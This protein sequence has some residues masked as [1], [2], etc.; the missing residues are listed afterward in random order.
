MASE[1]SMQIM[2]PPELSLSDIHE[3]IV[4]RSYSVSEPARSRELSGV[5][6]EPAPGAECKLTVP[7]PNNFAA[8]DKSRHNSSANDCGCRSCG[9][10]SGVQM[11]GGATTCERC[12]DITT[13]YTHSVELASKGSSAD[14]KLQDVIEFVNV[15]KD[16]GVLLPPPSELGDGNPF[17]MF[18]CLT[19][20]LEH[21]DH[22]IRR[23]MDYCRHSILI[24]FS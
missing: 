6:S 14:R 21:R 12:S 20:L 7:K 17:M 4:E 23:E 1:A 9:I 18:I 5:I 16:P 22:I 10:D 15:E 19:L 2:A 8:A 24:T 3:L 11:S 13:P